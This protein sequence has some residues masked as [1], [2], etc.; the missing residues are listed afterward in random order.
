MH[1]I[2]LIGGGRMGQALL[3]GW[4]ADPSLGPILVIEP[5]PSQDLLALRDEKRL[6]VAPSLDAAA[7]SG[8]QNLAIIVAIK[9]QLF[10]AV[11]PAYLHLSGPETLVISIAAGKTLGDLAHYFPK[12]LLVRAMPNTPAEFGL[13]I[14]GLVSTPNLADTARA[15]AQKIMSAVGA[16]EWVDHEALIDTV[17][18]ISGS[19]PAYVFLFVEALTKAAQAQGLAPESAARFARAT[20]IGAAGLLARRSDSPAALRQ[21]VTSPGGTTA[22]ALGVLMA[23]GA[24]EQLIGDAVSAAVAR[25]RELGGIKT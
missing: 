1:P 19:G 11:L 2:L 13:G 25:A 5:S 6:N 16:V 15:H 10:E 7:P 20:I 4:L 22:A 21:A 17:T 18:A 23:P 14:T 8:A 9:P 3:N 24:L 12:A